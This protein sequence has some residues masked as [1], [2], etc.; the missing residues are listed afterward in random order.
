MLVIQGEV[1]IFICGL[2]MGESSLVAAGFGYKIE[3]KNG[4]ESYN[5][6]ASMHIKDFFLSRS[7][8]DVMK[9]WNV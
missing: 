4:E 7:A 2:V 5:N 8:N 3:E 9:S 6:I 1:F